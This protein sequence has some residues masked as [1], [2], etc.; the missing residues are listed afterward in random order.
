MYDRQQVAFQ[1]RRLANM[2]MAAW[3]KVSKKLSNPADMSLVGVHGKLDA[4]SYFRGAPPGLEMKYVVTYDQQ[5]ELPEG[6]QGF[7]M[8]V[9]YY[10][11]EEGEGG[12]SPMGGELYFC[13]SSPNPQILEAAPVRR[14]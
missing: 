13:R 10:G 5:R 8:A 12:F 14:G 9:D 4:Q 1:S 2:L 3:D 7:R 6:E 11:K